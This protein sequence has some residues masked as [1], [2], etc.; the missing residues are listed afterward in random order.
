MDR[1]RDLIL[2]NQNPVERL[3]IRGNGKSPPVGQDQN[4]STGA[5]FF[6]ILD[7]FQKPLFQQG[8]FTAGDR[9]MRD[10]GAEISELHF[11]FIHRC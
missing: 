4:F 1:D 10:V 11:E 2:G 7:H 8:G 5:L 9:N 3:R 6:C